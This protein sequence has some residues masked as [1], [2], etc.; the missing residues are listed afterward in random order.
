MRLVNAFAV[1][2]LDQEMYMMVEGLDGT[3]QDGYSVVRF[4]PSG[5]LEFVIPA[6]GGMALRR[7]IHIRW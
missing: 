2:P 7:Y 1:K 3:T 5:D 6:N 4:D